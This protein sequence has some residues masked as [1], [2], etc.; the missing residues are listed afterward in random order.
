MRS[1]E[2]LSKVQTH[3]PSATPTAAVPTKLSMRSDDVC[4][5]RNKFLSIRLPR[6]HAAAGRTCSRIHTAASSMRQD[7]VVQN[8]Y[9]QSMQTHQRR[10]LPQTSGRGRHQPRASARCGRRLP[11]QFFRSRSCPWHGS[12][13]CF[14]ATSH[15]LSRPQPIGSR[16]W[17]ALKTPI[18]TRPN[19]THT[20][21]SRSPKTPS[22]TECNSH[23][24]QQLKLIEFQ[25]SSETERQR[26]RCFKVTVP[27]SLCG[28]FCIPQW[29][30][31][32]CRRGCH[33]RPTH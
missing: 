6:L 27:A 29:S 9:T 20:T 13:R 12:R 3:T 26:G 19:V 2:L 30:P 22:V 8:N 25:V 5:R 33:E 21:H 4:M 16:E 10:D 23:R 7:A 18:R 32:R 17:G 28:P 24:I 14:E 15:T 11:A 31:A 1:T